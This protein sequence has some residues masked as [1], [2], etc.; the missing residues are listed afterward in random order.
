MVASS[1]CCATVNDPTTA[2]PF[3]R[4]LPLRP[5][6]GRT[7]SRPPPTGGRE[8]RHDDDGGERQDE[9][10]E[11]LVDAEH[12]AERLDEVVP[13]EHRDRTSDH[14]GQRTLHVG[15]A[16]IQGAQGERAERGAEAGPMRRR[17][18]GR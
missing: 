15:A 7:R 17:R 8:Q 18:R 11:Q 13:D 14:A 12:A 2:R 5:C 4:R 1:R 10:G 6:N 16:P 9:R 3:R